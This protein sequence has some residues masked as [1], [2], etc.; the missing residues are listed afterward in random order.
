MLA[1][2]LFR[3]TA[4]LKVLT[5]AIGVCVAFIIGSFAFANG[6][7]T[8]VQSISDKFVSEGALAYQG[9]NLEASLVD[10]SQ[11]DT[12]HI[13]ASVAICV[14]S[15]NGNDRT[16]F[17]VNDSLSTLNQNLVPLPG[18]M[19]SGLANPLSGPVILTTDEGNVSLYANHTY[20]SSKFPAYWNLMRWD[21]LVKLRPEMRFNVSFVIFASS[22]SELLNS[23]RSQGLTVQEMTGILSYFAA[24]SN[25]VTSDLWL[26]IIP[27][28]FIV[29]LLV[30]SAVS[31][32]AKDRARDIAILKAMG[33]ND[34]QIRGVFFFQALMLSVLGALVGIL[35]GIIV[36]YGISTASS[37]LIPDSIFM[38]RVTEASMMVALVSTIIAGLLGS[39]IPVYNTVRQTVREALR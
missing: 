20:S 10:P 5:F 14:A 21:D 2:D 28:S 31:M 9:A 8:T 19:V 15:V 33:S 11:M 26:I 12:N 16:F 24:G 3:Y 36:S 17:A 18:E 13:Y 30:Y 29:A 38:L 32:E 34:R 1:L 25:E 39:V 7:S 6:L 27:S 23:L 35:I 37:S 22:D 4:R